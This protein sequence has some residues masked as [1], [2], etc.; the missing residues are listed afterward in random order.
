MVISAIILTV[1]N[2]NLLKKSLSSLFQTNFPALKVLVFDNGSTEDIRGRLKHDAFQVEVLRSPINLGFAEGNNRAIAYM[3]K[4]YQ[5]DY[6]LLFNNDALADRNLF[7]ICLPHLRKKVDLLCPTTI[8]DQNR[9]IDNVGIDYYRSGYAHGRLMPENKAN[10]ISG[11][12]LFISRRLAQ[13]S[14][15]LLGWVFNPLFFSYAEDL[16]LALRARLLGAKARVLND[17]LV[18][19]KRSVTYGEE[20]RF[21][22][23][24]S[25]RNLLWTIITTWPFPTIIRNAKYI[26]A[27]Q[28]VASS[29]YA[30]DGDFWLFPHVYLSTLK[31]LSKLLKVRRKIMRRIRKTEIWEDVFAGNIANWSTFLGNRKI[32]RFGHAL[33]LI[34]DRLFT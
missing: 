17:K 15:A 20:N 9:G 2:Y 21:R 4:K 34:Y 14:F 19:H 12:C 31:N 32:Y 29:L 22:I 11:C 5:P 23:F 3:L 1:N 27:G 30:W 18:V 7:R 6:F 25:W 13:K 26:F 10:L 24:I 16:E 33:K 28:L 8:L